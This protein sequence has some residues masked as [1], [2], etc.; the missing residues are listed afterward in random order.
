METNYTTCKEIL[1]V[2]DISLT[3][4]LFFLINFVLF[5]AGSVVLGAAIWAAWDKLS[6]IE[7]IRLTEDEE[8]RIK[9]AAIAESR[10][11]NRT[12]YVIIVA[13][14]FMLFESCLGYR[15]ATRE[16]RCF[17]NYYVVIFL[18]ILMMEMAAVYLGA[19]YAF[20]GDKKIKAYLDESLQ[21]YM[22]ESHKE[23]KN[24]LTL[25]WDRIMVDFQ[26]CAF[27]DFKDLFEFYKLVFSGSELIP[28]ECCILKDTVKVTPID[29]TCV[30]RPSDKNSY[31]KKPCYGQIRPVIAERMKKTINIAIGII[32]G[33][34]L[35]QSVGMILAFFLYQS[36]QIRNLKSPNT[37]RPNRR[38][39]LTK[40]SGL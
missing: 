32:S 10:I 27:N 7:F 40:T 1:C 28:P 12:I 38:R 33:L 6:F 20:K 30:N 4:R 9:L 34:V 2:W 39:L 26:C 14:A 8:L 36:I 35:I 16:S 5:V 22:P 25:L 31:W 17:L 19:A 11:I 24:D 13:V 15:G 21:K 29:K 37:C 18:I 3:K 23:H